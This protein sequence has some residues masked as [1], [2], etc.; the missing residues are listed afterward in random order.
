MQLSMLDG[1]DLCSLRRVLPSDADHVA[2]SRPAMNTRPTD[3]DVALLTRLAERTAIPKASV[4]LRL[5]TSAF[6]RISEG[7]T[8]PGRSPY[9]RASVARDQCS[10]KNQRRLHATRSGSLSNARM[11]RV[12]ARG[13]RKTQEFS[14]PLRLVTSV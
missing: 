1:L 13:E 8:P 14:V 9:L 6:R 3:R 7:C 4:P 10:Q 11:T 5:V 2:R 12:Q